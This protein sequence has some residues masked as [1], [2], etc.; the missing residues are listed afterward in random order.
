MVLLCGRGLV[1]EHA[2]VGGGVGVVVLLVGLVV[3]GEGLGVVRV[4][5]MEVGVDEFLSGVMLMVMMVMRTDGV[6]F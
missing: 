4:G 1:G 2:A 3:G 5:I 6:I